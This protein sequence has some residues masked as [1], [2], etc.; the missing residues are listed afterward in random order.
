MST[1][2]NYYT[3]KKKWKNNYRWNTQKQEPGHP[4]LQYGFLIEDNCKKAV[5]NSVTAQDSYGDRQDPNSR[6]IQR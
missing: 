5:V 3:E 2:T 6:Q 1:S 4:R